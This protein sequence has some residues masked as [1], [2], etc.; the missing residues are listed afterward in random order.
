MR[1]GREMAKVI[2]SKTIIQH[3]DEMECQWLN[4]IMLS[5]YRV[6]RGTNNRAKAEM[7]AEGL[8]SYH[9]EEFDG[10]WFVTITDKGKTLY[11]LLAEDLKGMI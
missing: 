11:S 4:E 10:T 1:I 9:K 2:I 6:S 7:A 5:E 8:I 3:G